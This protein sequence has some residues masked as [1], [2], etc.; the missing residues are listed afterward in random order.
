MAA[1][2]LADLSAF[3]ARA[4][5]ASGELRAVDVIEAQLRRIASQGSG[6]RGLCVFRSGLATRG[7][8]GARRISRER[9]AHRRPPRPDR[10]TERHHR[11]RD[12]PTE[13]GTP[14][15]AGRRPGK[16][17]HRAAS[18]RGGRHRHRQD[19]DHRA[20]LPSPGKTRNPHDPERTPGGSSSGSAAA[21]AAG[22]GAVCGWLADHSV[23][24]SARPRSAAWSASSRPTAS[25]RAPASGCSRARWTRSA[26][27]PA[28][29]QTRQ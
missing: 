1:T 27:S 13:N 29:W 8:Q 9:P 5:M 18:A 21:V 25:F 24:S 4:R 2:D 16:T 6:H 22:H 12:L 17:R 23:P 20:G 11:Y 7:R 19:R 14:I 26:C 28:A 10:G 15:D 3:D